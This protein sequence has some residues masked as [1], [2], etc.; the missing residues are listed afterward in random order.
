[1]MKDLYTIN[2]DSQVYLA[3][4]LF[5]F[6]MG[7]LFTQ[8]ISG[9]KL[10]ACPFVSNDC[11]PIGIIVNLYLHSEGWLSKGGEVRSWQSIHSLLYRD[12]VAGVLVARL[13]E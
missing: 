11:D 4:I 13:N 1:M 10:S 5:Q 2:L 3:C 6:V 7:I 12:D 9:I 8:L